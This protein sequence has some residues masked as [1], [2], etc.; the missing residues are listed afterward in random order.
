MLE[1]YLDHEGKNYPPEFAVDNDESKWGTSVK[2]IPVKQPQSILAIPQD[3]LRLL[4]CSICYR[5]IAKQLR[6]MG[7]DNYYI[8]VQNKDWL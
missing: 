7:I 1:Y 5:E 8:Y 3:N 4:I 2:G 6:E